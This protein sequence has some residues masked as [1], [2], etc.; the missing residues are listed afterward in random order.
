MTSRQ[1]QQI[2]SERISWY[3]D[4]A[5]LSELNSQKCQSEIYM[6]NAKNY[7]EQCKLQ[8]KSQVSSIML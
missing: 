1:K 2:V 8:H 7:A 3:W 4:L 5:I 6:C